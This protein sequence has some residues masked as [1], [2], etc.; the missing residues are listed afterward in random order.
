MNPVSVFLIVAVVF[1]FI[2]VAMSI[3][4][5]EEAAK[6]DSVRRLTFAGWCLAVVSIA[7]IVLVAVF[8]GPWALETIDRSLLGQAWVAVLLAIPGVIAGVAT[9]WLG[10]RLLRRLDV[11][12]WRSSGPAER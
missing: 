10:T 7:V 3:P 9:F 8:V 2:I 6:S 12:V 1:A 5:E 4:D 11:P